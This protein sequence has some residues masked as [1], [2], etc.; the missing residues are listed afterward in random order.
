MA[1]CAHPIQNGLAHTATCCVSQSV[2]S[3]PSKLL[4]ENIVVCTIKAN[5]AEFFKVWSCQLGFTCNARITSCR[6][7]LTPIAWQMGPRAC[8]RWYLSFPS[9]SVSAVLK[10][11]C[12]AQSTTISIMMLS[13]AGPM[14]QESHV[15]SVIGRSRRL[16]HLARL[17]DD[18][19]PKRVLFGHMD[20]SALG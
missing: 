6:E 15:L 3:G 5:S 10:L 1:R 19:L 16:G 2:A 18:R 20:G 4:V 11:K 12:K 14:L 13:W 9:Q 17:P 8:H 7:Y